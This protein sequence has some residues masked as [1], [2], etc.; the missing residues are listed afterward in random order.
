M[1]ARWWPLVGLT[2]M[3]LLGW[4]VRTGPVPIDD[5]FQH[6]GDELGSYRDVFL[7]FSTPLV[8]VAALL[9]GIVV[10]LRRH[11]KRLALA[12]VV[13]PLVAITVVR[14]IKPIFGREKGGAL[15][16]PSGHTTFLVAVTS[17]LV[18]LAGMRLWALVA[19]VSVVLLGM[20]GLSMTFHYFTDTVGGVLLGTSVVGIAAIFARDEHH[21]GV[22]SASLDVR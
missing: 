21:D 7:V 17:L 12:M 10:A 20:F 3:V 16:Y 1:I 5:R 9:V 6:V 2:A 14:V 15:A 11:R 22:G 8:V 19:A 18:L 13:S 4:A